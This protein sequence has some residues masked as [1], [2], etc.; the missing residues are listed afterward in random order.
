MRRWIAIPLVLAV[1]V[2]SVQAAKR[3]TVAQLEQMLATLRGNQD[4]DVAFRIADQELTER[5]SPSRMGRLIAELPGE[6]S[7]QALIAIADAS[8]FQSPP[9]EEIRSTAPPDGAEQRRIMALVVAYVTKTIPQLPNFIA[10]RTTNRFEDSPQRSREDLSS[11]PYEPLHFVD[12]SQ[13]TVGYQENHEVEDLTPAA[14]KRSGSSE[15]G[16]RSR[17]E[18]GSIL[19]TVLLDAAQNQLGWLRWEQGESGPLAAFAYSVP[20]EKSHFELDFCCVQDSEG[21]SHPLREV[22]GYKG[23]MLVDPATGII[24][25]LEVIADLKPGGPMRT[26][27]TVVEYGPVEIGGRTY[28]CPLHSIAMSRAHAISNEQQEMVQTA[29]HGQQGLGMAGVVVGTSPNNMEQ[30]LV[31]DVTFT[32]YHVFRA[33]SRMIAGTAADLPPLAATT[34]Q[35]LGQDTASAQPK[36]DNTNAAVLSSG[37]PQPETQ[38][39]S[40]GLPAGDSSLA[41]T[42]AEPPP[43]PEIRFVETAGLPDA[44]LQSPPPGD[45]SG[46]RLRTTTRLVDVGLVAYDK[47]GHPITD[48]HPGDFEIYDNGRRQEI[49]YLGQASPSAASSLTAPATASAAPET[50]YSNRQATPALQPRPAAQESHATILLI[51]SA[52]LAWTDLQNVRQEMLRF[53]KTVPTDE[54]VGLYIL[55]G[56]SFQILLEA[57]VDHGRIADTLTHWMPDALDLQRAQAEERVNRQQIDYVHSQQDLTRVNG[58]QDITDPNSGVQPLDPQLRDWGR[59]P[60]TDSL[61]LLVGVARHLAAFSG[62]KN[63]VWVTSDNALAD[64]SGKSVSIEKGSTSIEP[65]TLRAQEAMNEAHVSIYPL[66]A[67]QL[68]GGAITADMQNRNVKVTPTN[69]GLSAPGQQGPAGSKGQAI[70][71]PSGEDVSLGRDMRPGRIA[72]SMQQDLHAIQGPIRE[73]AEATGGRALRRAGD[74]AGELNGIAEDGRAAYLLSFTPD[75]PADGKYHLITVKLTARR[76]VRLRYRTGYLYQKEPATLKDRFQQAIWQPQDVNDIG[77][78]ALSAPGAATA[79]LKVSITATDLEIAQTGDRWTD[80]LDI[81]LVERDDAALHAKYTGRT[82]GLTLLPATYQKVLHDGIA[83]EQPLPIKPSAGS[84]RIVVVDENSGRMGSVTIPVSAVAAR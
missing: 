35:P 64:W 79:S 15:R 52:N 12:R 30:T 57:I 43:D 9:A 33:E 19:S 4:S 36:P 13:V 83:L 45:T 58:H 72:A 42:M 39:A 37:T 16:L 34:G 17:G 54:P 11:I 14:K 1:F 22:A 60:G 77:L 28:I 6:K 49:K 76:D 21:R 40:A 8:Q 74:I 32:Q 3:A 10:T 23:H 61:S 25:R 78:T 55:R 63:L 75:Q 68:E 51:D 53:L 7:R 24:E 2:P 26:A 67:S 44:P 65:F 50:V 66:D 27:R 82:L 5:L 46:F 80:K 71:S 59:T 29:A 69:P 48:L 41:G 47:K 84:Y 18:F 20:K 70:T 73:L 38:G 81:F 56:N 62:H 31:N